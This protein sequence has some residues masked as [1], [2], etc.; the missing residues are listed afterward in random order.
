VPSPAPRPEPAQPGPAARFSLRFDSGESI[1]I[2]A[3]VLLGRNP[4]AT[5]Y[6]G[7]SAIALADDSRSLSKTHML[8]RPVDGGLEI[9]DCR[10]TNGSGVIRGGTEYGVAAGTP[11]LATDGDMIRLGDR[12]AAVVRV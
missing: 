6:P 7:A 11:T 8:V 10:S 1:P 5:D 9:V 2:S 12:V 4:D 3:P